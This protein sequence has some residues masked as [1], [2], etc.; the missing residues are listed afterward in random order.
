MHRSKIAF[1][2]VHEMYINN[3]KSVIFDQQYF[4]ATLENVIKQPTTKICQWITNKEYS[5]ILQ[6]ANYTER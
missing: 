3:D 2:K 6:T 4:E 5:S 1:P